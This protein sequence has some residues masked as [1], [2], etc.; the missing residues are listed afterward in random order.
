MDARPT[1]LRAKCFPLK[2]DRIKE[3]NIEKYLIELVSQ[4]LINLYE[5]DNHPYL[6]MITWEDHQQIRA[7]KSKYPDPNGHLIT[8]DNICNQEISIVSKCPRNPIQSNPIRISDKKN[9]ELPDFIEKELWDDFLDMRKKIKKPATFKAQEL[10]IKKLETLK[11]SGEDPNEVIR[12]S[13]MNSYQSLFPL[14]KES[15]PVRANW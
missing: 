11:Q 4:K 10:L 5:I 13:I 2:I 9:I 14:K 3:T 6:E 1:V 12:Q 15:K 8:S 7:K